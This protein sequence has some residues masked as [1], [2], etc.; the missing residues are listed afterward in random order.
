MLLDLR[1]SDKADVVR[2]AVA[3]HA[4]ALPIAIGLEHQRGELLDEQLRE[5]RILEWRAAVFER[6]GGGR[7]QLAGIRALRGTGQVKQVE[8]RRHRERADHQAERDRGERRP[9]GTRLR[10]RGV[11]ARDPLA[12]RDVLRHRLRHVERG[13][14]LHVACG[15]RIH[16]A[17]EL[18]RGERGI[19]QC[20]LEPLLRGP[21]QDQVDLAQRRSC[22]IVIAGGD[23]GGQGSEYVAA[24]HDA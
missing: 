24:D 3:I 9:A 6:P 12:I 7:R 14:P 18:V 20:A 1:R 5:R 13:H 22:G 11:G 2:I 23:P 8:P 16:R 10:Q 15:I 21:P 17:T 4:A 19:D